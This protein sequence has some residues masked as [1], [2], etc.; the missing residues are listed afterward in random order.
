MNVI[1]L[2]MV[3]LI[4]V[5]CR[6]CTVC[7]QCF[8]LSKNDVRTGEINLK[9]AIKGGRL[10]IL[11]HLKPPTSYFDPPFINFSNFG[12]ASNFSRPF[13]PRCECR[14]FLSS[15]SCFMSCCF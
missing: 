6:K 13:Y 9:P 8:A 10:L 3:Y 15:S 12:V 5:Y 7:C 11:A 2:W 14:N 1:G 4:S